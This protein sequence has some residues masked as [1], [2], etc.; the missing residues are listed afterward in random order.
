MKTKTLLFALLL[1]GSTAVYATTPKA[2][3]CCSHQHTMAVNLPEGNAFNFHGYAGIKFDGDNRIVAPKQAAAGNPWVWRARFWGHQPQAD[4]K[5]LEAGYHI[6][7]CDV[8][9]LFGAP[10]AVERWDRFYQEMV[11]RGLA[12]KVALEAMSRG[13]LIAFNWAAQNREKVACIYAD[14]PVLDIK[15]WPMGLY[16]SEGHTGARD[17]M[18]EAYGFQ[19]EA[20]AI[21]WKGNPLDQWK[22]LRKIP[23]LLV[24]GDADVVVPVDEN[25]LVLLNRIPSIRYINKPGVGH[26]PHSLVDPTPIV[27]FIQQHASR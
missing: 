16:T 1:S 11:G 4:L 27:D 25:S 18:F 9:G 2:A 23:I 20:E 12:K 6:A 17:K 15:S 7:Y 26:H 13:G 22:K 8:M 14:A 24:C 3:T 21:R 19:T 10:V 5:L